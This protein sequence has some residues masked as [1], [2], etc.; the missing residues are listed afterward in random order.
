M[1]IHL[2]RHIHQLGCQGSSVAIVDCK[3]TEDVDI[4]FQGDGKDYT[5]DKSP[6]MTMDAEEDILRKGIL[7]AEKNGFDISQVRITGWRNDSP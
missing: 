2:E 1:A 5:H 7:I 6:N 3:Q 4:V